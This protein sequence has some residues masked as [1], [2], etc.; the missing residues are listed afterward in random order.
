MRRK[1]NIYGN[2]IAIDSK[3]IDLIKCASN[4]FLALRS[5]FKRQNEIFSDL[6]GNA[7]QLLDLISDKG[8]MGHL[9]QFNRLNQHLVQLNDIQQ[10]RAK[11]F[12]E[13]VQND[14]DS[15]TYLYSHYRNLNQNFLTTKY[16]LANLKVS[17]LSR[18]DNSAE[19]E[20]LLDKINSLINKQ[21]L[22]E[23]E[24]SHGIQTLAVRINRQEYQFKKYAKQLNHLYQ[25]TLERLSITADYFSEIE[26]DARNFSNLLIREKKIV[27]D[28]I[29]SIITYLQYHD[30]VS[31]KVQHVQLSHK[32]LIK[33]LENR[34]KE[35]DFDDELMGR[36]RSIV[37]I[38]SALLVRANKEYQK[39]IQ[40]ISDELKRISNASSSLF[41]LSE[42]IL[43]Y[44]P[45]LRDENQN[46]LF[47]RRVKSIADSITSTTIIAKK[48]HSAI[49]EYFDMLMEDNVIG[50]IGEC[51]EEI[52]ELKLL[53]DR[54]KEHIVESG[55]ERN[56]IEQQSDVIA[57]LLKTA[58]TIRTQQ[59]IKGGDS[60]I[61]VD[62][63]KSFE[64]ELQLAEDA[65]QYCNKLIDDLDSADQKVSVLIADNNR[66]AKKLK[67]LPKVEQQINYYDLFDKLILS[68][69]EILGEIYMS[70]KGDSDLDQSV[71]KEE[72]NFIKKLYTMDTEHRIHDSIVTGESVEQIDEIDPDRDDQEHDVEFF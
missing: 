55:P 49:R 31:Q 24:I 18:S 57:N 50:S 72:L 2:F 17:L 58:E 37:N 33:G 68:I 59:M 15:L 44:Q 22:R 35:N 23:V 69:I 14:L 20:E 21:T 36:I 3:I 51:I 39:A 38:Q 42:T 6:H 43:K 10:N 19:L 52:A 27:D 67:A 66:F 11:R 41:S 29:S 32:D 70:I 34:L 9:D 54:L 45:F 46:P 62:L 64:S 16:L 56:I 25:V 61:R 26:D 53:V 65:L 5:L 8:I 1:H 28:S 40:V 4:D 47:I 63:T 30:I 71:Y 60:P 48:L 12:L 13:Q 7:E